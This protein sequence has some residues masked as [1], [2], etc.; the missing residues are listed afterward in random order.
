MFDS[1]L[2]T[3]L[4]K[5]NVYN[6]CVCMYVDIYIVTERLFDYEELAHTIKESEKSQDLLSANWRP[7][8]AGGVIPI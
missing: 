7:R 6:V 5:R 4:G 1:Q 8:K 3:S 2:F